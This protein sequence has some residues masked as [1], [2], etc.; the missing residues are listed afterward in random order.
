[1]PE[2]PVRRVVV[3]IPW[4]TL[5]RLALAA[6]IAWALLELIGTILVLLVA[7]LLAVTLDPLVCWLEARRLSRAA[8]STLITLLFFVLVGLFLWMTW[9]SLVEQSEMVGRRFA[10]LYREVEGRLPASW[11]EAASSNTGATLSAAGGYLVSLATSASSAVAIL[12]LGCVLTFYLLIDG[13]RVYQ[14]AL[15]FV[16]LRHRVR[17]QRTMDEGRRVLFGYMIGQVITSAIAAATTFVALWL[18]GVPAPLF[19]GL[20]AGLSDF[21]PVVGFVVSAVPALALAFAVSGKTA[22]IVAAVYVVY[23]A[24]ENYVISPWAYG[25][26]L[27]LSDFA[28]VV[29]FAVGAELAGVIGA[30]LALPIAAI[31]PTIERIWLREQL[32]DETLREHRDM[33]H[34]GGE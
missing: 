23:N 26:R 13:R 12:V 8:A 29:A 30:I 14:W 15:A 25:D 19:L 31:Y 4:R 33:E 34:Q 22:L 11:R 1:M 21:V 24:V 17:V 16:P 3:D 5:L 2:I 7:V 6:A 28:V 9:T 18:L 20:I 10:E 27:R 32:P